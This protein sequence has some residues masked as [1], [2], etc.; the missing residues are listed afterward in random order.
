MLTL[1]QSVHLALRR[2][3]A[4]PLHRYAPISNMWQGRDQPSFRNRPMRKGP[5]RKANNFV[6]QW[7]SEGDRYV[8]YKNLVKL[9]SS[10]TSFTKGRT[11]AEKISLL[12]ELTLTY[13][14]R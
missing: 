4:C 2:H 8:S 1:V 11:K 6:A 9:D 7:Q 14:A 5:E 12:S 13:F 3:S 10:L